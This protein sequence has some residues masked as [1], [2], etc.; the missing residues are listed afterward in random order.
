MRSKVTEELL[1]KMK[2]D[3][4]SG[5]TYKDIEKR[6]GVSRWVTIHYLRNVKIDEGVSETLWRKAE[7]KGQRFLEERGFSH[8]LD[9]NDISPQSY[10]DFYAEKGND[11]WLVDVAINES[12]DVVAKSLKLV[13]GFR[14]ASLYVG[15]DLKIFRMVELKEVE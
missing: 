3:R 1:V 5:A 14:C 15:H 2:A 7:L 8:I 10:F 6:Y 9:L 13:A 11:R 12:K 4:L